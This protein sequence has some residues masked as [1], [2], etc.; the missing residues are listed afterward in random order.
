MHDSTIQEH[1]VRNILRLTAICEGE[2]E[3]LSIDTYAKQ[4]SALH[5]SADGNPPTSGSTKYL[6][7]MGHD[8]DS[9]TLKAEDMVF[10]LLAFLLQVR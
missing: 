2:K 8:A 4:E 9:L 1:P 3:L 6:R 10:I 7:W 5:C